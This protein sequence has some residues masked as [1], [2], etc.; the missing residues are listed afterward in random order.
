MKAFNGLIAAA[1]LIVLSVQVPVFAKSASTAPDHLDKQRYIVVLEDL[2]LSAYDGR[3]MQTPERDSNSTRLQATATRFTGERKLDVKSER[4]QQYLR[5]LDQRFTAFYGEATLKL[6]RQLRATHRYRIAVNG[7][8]SELDAAEV[9]ALRD[10]PGVKA[11]H[12]DEVQ[13]L[14]T[15]SGPNWLGADK[16]HDGSAGYPPS[17]GEGVVIGIID[18]GINWDHSSFDDP[19]EGQ[20]P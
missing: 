13:R 15:D 5:F 8:A 3:V 7:F 11:I 19:G 4:S 1:I 12:F 2:P 20:P 17:G 10:M 14:H 6:G 16:V 9:A 18:S